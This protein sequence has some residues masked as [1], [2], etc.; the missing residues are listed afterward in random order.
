MYALLFFDLK[1]ESDIFRDGHMWKKGV[2]LEYSIEIA[3]IGREG[4]N[5][6]SV[7]QN[8]A[9]VRG[10]KSADNAQ[11][12]CLA[13][14]GRTEQCDEFIL[15]D[16]EVQIVQNDIVTVGFGNVHKID[17]F[18]AHS[19]ESLLNICRMLPH[20]CERSMIC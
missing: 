18:F 2:F 6:L 5:I 11:G 8:L 17:Q 10:L 20:V 15:T 19:G 9:F 1:S 12:C 16:V 14:A 7:K 3:L 4:G 13:A